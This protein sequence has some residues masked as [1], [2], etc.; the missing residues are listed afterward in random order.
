[1]ISEPRSFVV[2]KSYANLEIYKFLTECFQQWSSKQIEDA[3]NTKRIKVQ[4]NGSNATAY[5]RVKPH[6]KIMVVPKKTNEYNSIIEQQPAIIKKENSKTAQ[7]IETGYKEIQTIAEKLKQQNKEINDQIITIKYLEQIILQKEGQI[8]IL[9]TENKKITELN[10]KHQQ[11]ESNLAQLK[12]ELENKKNEEIRAIGTLDEKTKLRFNALQEN[13][14]RLIVEYRKKLAEY[15]NELDKF[16]GKKTIVENENPQN[17]D[18]YTVPEKEK[19]STPEEYDSWIVQKI[20][21]QEELTHKLLNDHEFL[22]EWYRKRLE[23]LGKLENN[24]PQQNAEMNNTAGPKIS[25]I[26]DVTYAFNDFWKKLLWKHVKA[27]HAYK[28]QKKTLISKGRKTKINLIEWIL[29]ALVVI[30][31]ILVFSNVIFNWSDKWKLLR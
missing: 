8:K 24:E 30:L 2:N 26:D 7:K 23:S 6:D 21:E 14:Y 15:Q 25:I 5:N 27:K 12:T 19:I 11:L 18:E 29:C 4:I 22:L 3:I 17:T 1:M 28:Q 10:N 9:E 20:E 16:K 31:S 13:T